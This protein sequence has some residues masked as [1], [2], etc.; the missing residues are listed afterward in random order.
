MA[1]GASKRMGSPKQLLAIDGK[2]LVRRTSEIA[3]ATECYPVVLVIGAHKAQIAP[4]IIDLPLTVIDNQMWHE[5]M[6]SSLKIGLAGMYMTYK[7]IDAVIM[8]C[9]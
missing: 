4:E 5:G 1:A 3:L 9:M 2:S 7:D 6:A 8:L